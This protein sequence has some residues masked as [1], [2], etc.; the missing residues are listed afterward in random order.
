MGEHQ[1]IQIKIWLPESIYSVV[2]ELAAGHTSGN[3]SQAVRVLLQRGLEKDALD[4]AADE[5]IGRVT[6]QLDH[7]ERLLFFTAVEAARTAGVMDEATRQ[8]TADK[9]KVGERV[10]EGRRLKAIQQIRQ[11]LRGPNA[12]RQGENDDEDTGDEDAD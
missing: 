6:S 12:V 5:V 9:P 7:P 11:A 1:G 3:I 4:A 8:Q 2:R 10:I